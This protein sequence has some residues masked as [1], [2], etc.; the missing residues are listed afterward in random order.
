M[1]I[2][3]KHTK[4]LKKKEKKKENIWYQEI[5]K[6][7]KETTAGKKLGSVEAWTQTARRFLPRN[8]QDHWATEE[9]TEDEFKNIIFKA[10]SRGFF[11][12]KPRFKLIRAY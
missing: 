3:G 4:G 11:A 5:K 8:F 10:F 9:Y 6:G 1:G 12:G 2:K 7:K